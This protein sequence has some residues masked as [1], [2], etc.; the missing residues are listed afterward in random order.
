M[1]SKFCGL[2]QFKGMKKPIEVLPIPS[3]GMGPSALPDHP[4][5]KITEPAV[6]LGLLEVIFL[7]YL[8]HPQFEQHAHT[9]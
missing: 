9:L 2:L 5:W 7:A 8:V 6:A 4:V 3:V 1:W